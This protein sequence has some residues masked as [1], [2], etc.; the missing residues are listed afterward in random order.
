VAQWR[1]RARATKRQQEF[2]RHFALPL[3]RQARGSRNHMCSETV[4]CRWL[5]LA[6]R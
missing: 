2:R 1:A 5:P 6:H 4:V 3:A